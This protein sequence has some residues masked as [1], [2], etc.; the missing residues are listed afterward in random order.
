MNTNAVFHAT[1]LS[2]VN[3]N[4]LLREGSSV[5]VRIL[6]NNGNNS[7]LASF[8][9]QK[10]LLKSEISLREGTE[11]FAKI[12]FSNG[13]IVLQK[14]ASGENAKNSAEKLG[15]E[16]QKQFLE[17]LGLKPDNISI[18]TF[19]QMKQLGVRYD[20]KI[21]E[22]VRKIA[23][24]IK[25][26]QKSASDAAFI[27]EEKGIS[28]DEKKVLAILDNGNEAD[29]FSYNQNNQSKSSETN[30][31]S[32]KNFFENIFKFAENLKNQPGILTLFNHF[33]FE[34][35]TVGANGNWIKIPFEFSAENN[36]GN[37]SFCAFI[38]NSSKMLEKS[39]L[40]FYVNGEQYIFEF[41]LNGKNLSYLNFG[42]SNFSKNAEI[43][44]NLQNQFG[45]EKIKIGQIYFDDGF[46]EFLADNSGISIARL[47]V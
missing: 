38:K 21:F 19:L 32:I 14:I 20:Q 41:G 27:M 34:Q 37:G 13:K 36:C 3:V 42:C 33:G 15:T 43:L 45:N 28:A 18:A 22:K 40:N 1:A 31:Q 4:G 47:E 5:Y 26:K 39:V 23:E 12:K 29:E 35:K 46:S 11:F 9:G 30:F 17:N 25:N 2:N 44:K 6:K 7:Y 8:A 16:S 10:I 24:K